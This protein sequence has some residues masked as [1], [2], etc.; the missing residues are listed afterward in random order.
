MFRRLTGGTPFIV[1]LAMVLTSACASTRS[2]VGQFHDAAIT[3]KVKTKLAA[4][5]Q[6]NPFEIDV[7]TSK[8]VVYLS[9]AVD[10]WTERMEAE[11]LARDTGGVV[12]VVNELSFGDRSVGERLDDAVIASKVKA[13][14][15]A[16]PDIDPFD[17][18]VDVDLGV[19]TL[20]GEVAA[21]YQKREAASIAMSTG[22]VRE[23]HN[24]IRVR[25]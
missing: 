4:D 17:I 5:P 2:T 14:L 13:K 16:D 20:R 12:G 22:G 1:A 7:D 21:R 25:P 23:V 9:G 8:G 11:S 10:S 15:A 18:D 24:R 3:A 19:V 6:V